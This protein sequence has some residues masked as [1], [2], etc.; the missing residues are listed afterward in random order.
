MGRTKEQVMGQEE[1]QPMYDWIGENF[2]D[3]GVE[4][5]SIEW[6]QAVKAF[7]HYCENKKCIEEEEYWQAQLEWYIYE[8]SQAGT[9]NSQMVNVE[10]LL[11]TDLTRDESRFSLLVMLH[12]HVV[13]SLEAYLAG[14]FIHNVTSSEKLIRKL[15]ETDPHF[16]N[17]K[18]T[19][20][21]IF[22]KK[23]QLKLTVADYLQNLI[24]H[25]LKKVK[26]MFKDVLGCDFGDISW[27]FNA[28]IKRHHCVHRAGLDK[29]GNRIE[30]SADSIRVLIDIS[31]ELVR[32]IEKT[33]SLTPKS[34]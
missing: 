33:I 28:V 16:S 5:G 17:T 11:H 13:A 31:K 27:L 9:F 4:E 32:K 10:E 25:D 3:D 8:Q 7:E 22:E 18:F 26:P 14:T 15:V 30:L 34:D 6:T 24:F 12:G 23:E 19:I 2:G 29:D 1:L 21:E 20:K